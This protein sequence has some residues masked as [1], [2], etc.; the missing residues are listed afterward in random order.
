MVAKQVLFVEWFNYWF[1]SKILQ[2]KTATVLER[3][4]FLSL[5][6]LSFAFGCITFTRKVEP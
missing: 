2:S 4:I 5:P 6:H 3:I 1:Q